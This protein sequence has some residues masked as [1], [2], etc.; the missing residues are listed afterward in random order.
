MRRSCHY[1]PP[2]HRSRQASPASRR[3]PAANQ[4]TPVPGRTACC[5]RN[6]SYAARGAEHQDDVLRG[7]DD[8]PCGETMTSVAAQDTVTIVLSDQLQETVGVDYFFSY[9]I[10]SP[11]RFSRIFGPVS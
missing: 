3:R 4:Q 11:L 2:R 5:D 6:G 1:S 7:R 9:S 10:T 8:P